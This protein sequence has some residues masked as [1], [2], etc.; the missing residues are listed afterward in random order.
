MSNIK[1]QSLIYFLF[2]LNWH[3]GLAV[4]NPPPQSSAPPIYPRNPV[5]VR[6]TQWKVE[7][8]N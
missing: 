6:P 1:F 4:V 7:I 2:D 5:Q 8:E 3:G